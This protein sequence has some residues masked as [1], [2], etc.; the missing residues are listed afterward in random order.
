LS[1]GSGDAPWG[2]QIRTR[3]PITAGFVSVNQLP[4]ANGLTSAPRIDMR[5]SDYAV[6]FTGLPRMLVSSVSGTDGGDTSGF[7]GYLSAPRGEARF[8]DFLAAVA[9]VE[10]V[11]PPDGPAYVELD[12]STYN[13]YNPEGA[14][15]YEVPS[16]V[17]RP[18]E[19]RFN[20]PVTRL[21]LKGGG[22]NAGPP[23]Q[24]LVPEFNTSLTTVELSGENT[25][26]VYIY[27]RGGGGNLTVTTAG[28][29]ASFRVGMTLYSPATFSPAGSLTV[30]GGLRTDR[31]GGNAGSVTFVAESSPG[32]AYEAIADRMMW[33]EDQRAR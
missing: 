30:V 33:L 2:F 12:L 13:Y 9:A 20:I 32:W 22:E 16:S 18:L 5:Q 24:V 8:G 25:R 26:P 31:A 27:Q 3:S 23:V 7:L 1:T 6:G 21:V 10:P 17:D 4:A 29:G 14:L 11:V 19:G 28:A 15:F